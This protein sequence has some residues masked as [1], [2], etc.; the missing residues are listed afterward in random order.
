MKMPRTML[1]N[2]SI[3]VGPWCGPVKAENFF[4]DERRVY[5]ERQPDET[6]HQEQNADIEQTVDQREKTPML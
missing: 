2:I 4:D 5:A 6:V 3:N 1:F